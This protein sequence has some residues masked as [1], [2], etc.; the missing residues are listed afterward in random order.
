MSTESLYVAF[1]GLVKEC[2]IP[3]NSFTSDRGDEKYEFV[4]LEEF[5]A[6]VAYSLLN[7]RMFIWLSP[8]GKGS[9]ETLFRTAKWVHRPIFFAERVS[10]RG[11]V[12]VVEGRIIPLPHPVFDLIAKI[13]QL[14][15]LQDEEKKHQSVEPVRPARV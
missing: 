13:N 7:K 14:I 6:I 2:G 10:S 9:P 4:I 1:T 15:R 8:A 12:A 11:I 3:I 5:G